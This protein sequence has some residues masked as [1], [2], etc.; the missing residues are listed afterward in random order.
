M[1]G[2]SFDSMKINKQHWSIMNDKMRHFKICSCINPYIIM[3]ESGEYNYNRAYDLM[4][5]SLHNQFYRT[6]NDYYQKS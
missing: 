5:L 2:E 4:L 3:Q 6:R 1:L